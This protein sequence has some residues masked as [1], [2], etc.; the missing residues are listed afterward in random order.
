M[1]L[2]PAVL[3]NIRAAWNHVKSMGDHAGGQECLTMDVKVQAPGIAG[4]LRKNVEFLGGIVVSPHRRVHPNFAD[5]GLGED[6]VQP[7]KQAV[8]SPLKSVQRFMRVLTAESRQ[9]YLLLITF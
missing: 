7:I 6:A 1:T 2:R 3:P 9:Q 4:P 5:F 8:R